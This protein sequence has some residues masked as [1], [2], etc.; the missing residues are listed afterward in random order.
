[1]ASWKWCNEC[2]ASILDC[3]CGGDGRIPGEP[4]SE[5]GSKSCRCGEI[6][7]TDETIR[8]MEAFKER[9]RAERD[10]LNSTPGQGAGSFARDFGDLMKNDNDTRPASY[11]LDK[12]REDKANSYLIENLLA[13][14]V[15]YNP[16]NDDKYSDLELGDSFIDD[17]YLDEESIL[18]RY[19]KDRM[20]KWI[21]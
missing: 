8:A 2:F 11:W 15:F 9:R 16:T 13:Q 7:L 1:M 21:S 10:R 5:C 20:K 14:P 19:F 6:V 17:D 18:N 3:R 12:I 4:C